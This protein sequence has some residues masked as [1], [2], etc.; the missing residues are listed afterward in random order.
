MEYHPDPDFR[1]SAKRGVPRAPAD[2]TVGGPRVLVSRAALLH[3]A[4]VIRNQLEDGVQ[5]CAV[6]KADAYGHGAALVA[7]TLRNFSIDGSGRSAVDQLAVASV[8]EA[9]ALPDFEC[10]LVIL[11]PVENV[12]LG[13]NR[14]MLEVAVENGWTLTLTHP[15]AADDIARLA[16]RRGLLAR[17]QVML[18]TGM[19]RTGC[20]IGE[21]G[22][23]IERIEAHQSLQ[24]MSVGT[25]FANG[26]VRGD[27]FTG[28]QLRRF[29]EATDF[30]DE[31]F[32][33]RV[34]RHA[35]ASGA[36]FL[37][38]R[39]HYDVVRPGL[40][41]YG[42]DPTGRPSPD[43]P[44]RPALSW[45]APLLAVHA[46]RTG[47]G[48]GYG[49]TWR[50]AYPTR[51]GVVPVGYA[52]G[53]PRCLGNRAAVLIGEAVCPVAGNV[54]MDLLT[55]DLTAA[56]HARVGDTVTLLDADPLSP[57]SAYALAEWAGT[58]PYEILARIGPRMMRVATDPRDAEILA[59]PAEGEADGEHDTIA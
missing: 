59:N 51:V 35:A 50:A 56:P 53:Y 31:R 7:D 46:V 52:D 24:L 57:V 23:L 29:A 44:L 42:I 33:G 11:R 16:L 40:A 12:Y 26:E 43:R 19:T 28:E 2:P 47:E 49:Q 15:A 48:V 39:T 32:G 55:V 22:R 10:P 6:V 20:S 18:D 13:R 34:V 25:H 1:K 54:S 41:L 45:T 3:N 21:F 9:T 5:I 30:L 4:A 14:E 8:E 38:H 58:I 36:I 37:N 27:P 17:V